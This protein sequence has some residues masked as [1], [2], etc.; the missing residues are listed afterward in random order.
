MKCIFESFLFTKSSIL[1]LACFFTFGGSVHSQCLA[2]PAEPVCSGTPLSNGANINGGSTYYSNGGT[3]SGV[4]L[5]GGTLILCS[6]TTALSGTYNNGTI[7]T[8]SGAIL[9]TTYSTAGSNCSLYNYGTTNFNSGLFINTSAGA[10]MNAQGATINVIGNLAGNGCQMVNYGNITGTG[11]LGDWQNSGGIC[12]GDGATISVANITWSSLNNWFTTPNGNSCI[13]Y[14]GTATSGNSHPFSPNA[15]TTICQKVGASNESGSGSWG[16]ATLNQSCA[17]C[18]L[19]CNSVGGVVSSNATV[20]SGSNSGTLVLSGHN[21]NVVKWQSSTDNWVTPIDIVNITTSQSYSNIT[22]STKYR[23]VVQ[24][25]LC[26]AVNS[27]EVTITVDPVSVG[28]TV[29]AN[30][31]VCSG[32]NSG[33]LTL[34]GY[35]GSITGWESSTDNF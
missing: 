20:C 12:Q 29:S 23:A 3:F 6:G 17:A 15:G 21:G 34:S 32:S 24:D 5:N 27:A 22:A 33:T 8:K 18:G 9:N 16:G 14:S 31:T 35:T 4:A 10:F 1:F 26:A 19:T 25:G 30:T 7:V 28:G 13:S 11:T 2:M